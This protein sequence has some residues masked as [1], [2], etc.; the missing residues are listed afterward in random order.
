MTEVE[1]QGHYKLFI[2]LNSLFEGK[3]KHECIQLVHLIMMRSDNDKILTKLTKLLMCEDVI[4]KKWRL[5]FKTLFCSK[6]PLDD[7]DAHPMGVF[8][9]I[10]TQSERTQTSLDVKRLKTKNPVAQSDENIE[11]IDNVVED[12]SNQDVVIQP[13]INILHLHQNPIDWVRCILKDNAEAT[14]LEQKLRESFVQF[15]YMKKLYECVYEYYFRDAHFSKHLRPSVLL[16]VLDECEGIVQ[17]VFYSNLKKM[18]VDVE[19]GLL[20]RGNFVDN[21]MKLL[22]CYLADSLIFEFEYEKTSMIK[23][24]FLVAVC[25]LYT[26]TDNLRG[27]SPNIGTPISAITGEDPIR[28]LMPYT[29]I[30]E[31]ITA[32]DLQILKDAE[33]DIRNTP[34]TNESLQAS[35]RHKL[36]IL[37]SDRD[38][39]MFG[40]SSGIGGSNQHELVTVFK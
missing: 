23:L 22:H 31:P 6:N 34:M 3:F 40:Y 19:K 14:A 10:A 20:N 35:K 9:S 29:K 33:I 30:Y 27:L 11:I 21:A 7:C 25:L 24:V 15:K 17:I 37:Q 5:Y 2:T 13:R 26:A 28:Q 18:K 16:K 39:R 32:V 8:L 36:H 4:K 1:V 38:Y 12:V